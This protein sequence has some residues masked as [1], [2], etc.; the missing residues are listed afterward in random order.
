MS[1]NINE[2]TTNLNDH[3]NVLNAKSNIEDVSIDEH[4]VPL[5]D[6]YDPRNWGNLDTKERNILVEK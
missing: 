6:I 5:L 2:D 1:N 3:D 4:L